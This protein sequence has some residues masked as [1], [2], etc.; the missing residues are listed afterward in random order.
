MSTFL[1]VRVAVYIDKNCTNKER[2]T[3][4]SAFKNYCIEEWAAID[5]KEGGKSACQISLHFV[6]EF[7]ELDCRSHVTFYTCL[8]FFDLIPLR[9]K[10]YTYRGFPKKCLSLMHVSSTLS[11]VCL[12]DWR[13]RRSNNRKICRLVH[14]LTWFDWWNVTDKDTEEKKN[15]WK[16]K[17]KQ[18]NKYICKIKREN[19]FIL[20]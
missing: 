11:D 3:F 7:Q 2:R 19:S 16:E 10:C 12:F 18:T 1:Q 4:L 8:K 15:E 13:R 6:I 14:R 20:L 17:E 9:L 5:M